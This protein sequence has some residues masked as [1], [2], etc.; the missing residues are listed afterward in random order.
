M[1][2]GT[3]GRKG[4]KERERAEM[5][6]RKKDRVK[7]GVKGTSQKLPPILQRIRNEKG[8]CWMCRDDCHRSLRPC[9]WRRMEDRG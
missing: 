3:G 2:H 8:D 1:A 5:K 6:E 4:K 9:S 7:E